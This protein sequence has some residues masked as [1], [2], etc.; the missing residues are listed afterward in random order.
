LAPPRAGG[1]D[2]TGRL[3]V[4]QQDDVTRPD[5]GQQLS[6]VGGGDLGVVVAFGIP[7]RPGVHAVQ[8][9]VQPL[10]DRV[11]G[12]VA[13]DDQPAR[14]DPGSSGVRQQGGQHL[15]DAAPGGGGVDVPYRPSRK[16]VAAGGDQ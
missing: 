2:H 13:L 14:V 5:L 15:G 11:E 10:G 7:Q 1:V 3:R 9:V 12:G 4:V 8:A 16:G 6:G